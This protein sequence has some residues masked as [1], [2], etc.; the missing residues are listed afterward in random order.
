MPGWISSAGKAARNMVVELVKTGRLS[1]ARL[2]QSVRRLLRLKFQLG[3]FDNPFVDES[4]VPQVLGHPASVAAGAASQ[5]RAMT[6]L[7]NEDI[8]SRLQG[9]PKVFVKNIDPSV[10]AQ[11]AEVVATPEEADFAILRLET[12]W[13][14]VETK[15]PF[16]RGF[17]HGD[18][19][20]KGEAKAEI[21]AL[22]RLCQPLWCCIWI[23][24]RS[25]PKSAAR[26]RLAGRVWGQ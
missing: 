19:D 7:K 20:F 8:S 24:P 15:N 2:D 6:L 25:F 22:L 17:H 16:A 4:Q 1:E 18:L 5:K 3:L 21:L 13:V 11:Y 26:R 9:Q 14:P 10:A 12:P 23:A